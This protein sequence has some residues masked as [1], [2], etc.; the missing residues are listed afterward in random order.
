V[1]EYGIYCRVDEEETHRDHKEDEIE[2][3]DFGISFNERRTTFDKVT[4]KQNPS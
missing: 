3:S 4:K 1:Q 2:G